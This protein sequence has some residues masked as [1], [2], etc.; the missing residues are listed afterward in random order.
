MT[1]HILLEVAVASAADARTAAA[2]GAD[3]FEVSCGLEL[4]G[5]TATLGTLAAVLAVGLPLVVLLRPRPGGFVYTAKEARAV[6]PRPRHLP[7]PSPGALTG[8][9]D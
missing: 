1:P 8:E 2:A 5:L 4:D 6:M 9:Q 7:S 3:Q